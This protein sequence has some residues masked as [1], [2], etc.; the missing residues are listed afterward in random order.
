MIYSKSLVKPICLGL[1]HK[2]FK[3]K[4]RS[5]SCRATI[6]QPEL[7]DAYEK[8]RNYMN[9]PLTINSGYRCQ[10]HNFNVGGVSLSR[11]VLG[12]AIDIELTDTLLDV[13]TKHELQDLASKLGFTFIKFYINSHVS[14][15][16]LDVRGKL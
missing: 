7:V 1:S 6:I 3:C 5:S 2:E 4:C 8:F 10:N 11:H 12:A 13:Y 15:M 14:F 16:H 9:M